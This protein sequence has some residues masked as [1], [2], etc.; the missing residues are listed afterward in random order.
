MADIADNAD[1]TVELT[2]QLQLAQRKPVGPQATGFCL[3][4]QEPMAPGH[5]WCD[6]EC[7]DVWEKRNGN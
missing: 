5:R 6:A 4:C 1:S 2:L 7:R 3:N